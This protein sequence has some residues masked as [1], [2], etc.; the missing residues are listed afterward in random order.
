TTSTKPDSGEGGSSTST[1]VPETTT[2]SESSDFTDSVVIA[3]EEAP[4]GGSG[5]PPEGSGIREAPIGL[6]VAFDGGLFGT[7]GSLGTHFAPVDHNVDFRVIAETI[8]ASWVWIIILGSLIAWALVSGL[9]K[10]LE[11]KIRRQLQPPDAASD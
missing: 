11:G 6:Q 8:G 2:T 5:G 4:P 3:A 1:T 9:D 10:K 7:V